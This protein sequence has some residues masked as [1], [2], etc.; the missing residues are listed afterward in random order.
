MAHEAV[1]SNFIGR[2]DDVG[3][4]LGLKV[5]KLNLKVDSVDSDGNR[6]HDNRDKA[7]GQME[8][9][10]MEPEAEAAR[11]YKVAFERLK[12]A[13]EARGDC[14]IFEIRTSTR[15]LLGTGN[16]SVFEFGFNLNYPWGVPYISGSSLKGA[17]SSYLARKGGKD[18]ELFDGSEKSLAQVDVFGGNLK[19]DSNSYLGL[20]TFQ[21]AW[22]CPWG[23]REGRGDWFDEDIITPHHKSY[24]RGEGMPTGMDDPL[25]IKIAALCPGLRFQVIL[26]GPKK[27][28]EFIKAR[29]LEL[30]KDEGIGGKTAVGYGRF[31]YVEPPK[32]DKEK[33]EEW[34]IAQNF[35]AANKGRHSE[36]VEKLSKLEGDE[37]TEAVE[38]VTNTLKKKQRSPKLHE[39][40][41]SF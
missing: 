32:S 41:Q 9:F 7:L 31:E 40:L 22:I 29:L 2:F 39:Y 17:V 10:K 18:W 37:H 16:A 1:R 12:R 3:H 21:D 20:V 19:G 38:L 11:A 4:N 36:I 8:S 27:Y 33:F 34:F 26:Q 5:S 15:V 25:P 30:L 23:P 13:A 14:E 35:S 24:Y 28:T 6:E